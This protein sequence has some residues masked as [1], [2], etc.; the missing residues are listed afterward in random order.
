MNTNALFAGEPTGESPNQWGDPADVKLPNS[1]IVIQASTLWWQEDLRDN[2]PY[3]APDLSA[4]LTF[5]DYTS[6]VDPVMEAI[7]RIRH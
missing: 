3:R 7:K 1:G 2:R 6:N 5:A 4:D